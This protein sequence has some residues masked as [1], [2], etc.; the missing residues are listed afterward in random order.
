[1][2][3]SRT[4][5]CCLTI[6]SFQKSNHPFAFHTF[7]RVR[8]GFSGLTNFVKDD[9][10]FFIKYDRV[11]SAAGRPVN[12]NAATALFNVVENAVAFAILKLSVA[13]FAEFDE[14]AFAETSIH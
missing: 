2:S 9:S 10:F 6:N 3:F 13:L 1:M 4:P 5:L 11:D 14:E 7:F 12:I 8:Y